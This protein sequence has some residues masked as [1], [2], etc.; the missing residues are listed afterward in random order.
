M[1]STKTVGEAAKQTKTKLGKNKGILK[2]SWA[3]VETKNHQI[4]YDKYEFCVC[5]IL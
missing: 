1:D 3:F 5:V 2:P 4:Q